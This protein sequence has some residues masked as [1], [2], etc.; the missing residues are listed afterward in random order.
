MELCGSQPQCDGHDFFILTDE[1]AHMY[2]D[3]TVKK[4]L[5]GKPGFRKYITEGSLNQPAVM[6]VPAVDLSQNLAVRSN[7]SSALPSLLT[8]SV[9]WSIHPGL[10]SLMSS[11]LVRR[12]SQ[13][14]LSVP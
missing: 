4:P 1:E 12:R 8:G 2:L 10:N 13:I 3:A 11:R 6:D 7:L 5:E 14:T 9:L